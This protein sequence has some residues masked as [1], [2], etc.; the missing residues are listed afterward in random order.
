M[1]FS[2]SLA[3]KLGDR[4]L[5]SVSLNPGINFHTNLSKHLSMEDFSDL[6]EQAMIYMNCEGCVLHKLI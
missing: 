3:Q 6:G 2:V 4:N 1:L 5:V